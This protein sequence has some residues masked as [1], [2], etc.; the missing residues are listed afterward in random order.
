MIMLL[1]Y[2]SGSPP[3]PAPPI[4][5]HKHRVAAPHINTQKKCHS[6]GSP[7]CPLLPARHTCAS[8]SISAL[9][10]VHMVCAS[11][12]TLNRDSWISCRQ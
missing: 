4:N 6:G 7:P 10:A 1:L 3:L 9:S 2:T 8:A 12:S 5:T 11:A